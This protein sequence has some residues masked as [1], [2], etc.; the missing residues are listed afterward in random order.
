[1]S[2]ARLLAV[3]AIIEAATGIAL[4]VVPSTVG[5]LLLDE[6]LSG[7]GLAVGRVAGVA[8]LALG[9]GGWVGR[10]A[11]WQELGTGGYADLQRPDGHL[12]CLSRD[13]RC[14]SGKTAVASG[15]DPCRA[16]PAARP[17]L[18]FATDLTTIGMAAWR[19]GRER[20]YLRSAVCPAPNC[21][22]Y[23]RRSYYRTYPMLRAQRQ[24]N[25]LMF[26]KLVRRLQMGIG[27]RPVSGS[28]EERS[29]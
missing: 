28:R 9:V 23:T 2:V 10:K 27:C 22:R 26:R 13:R 1:M 16:G 6:S 4:I 12:P 20:R 3:A 25:P 29:S 19:A 7:A 24:G 15:C 21:E 8:L 5:W 11:T 14:P 18:V 17:R